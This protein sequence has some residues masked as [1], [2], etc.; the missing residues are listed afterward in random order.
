M[1]ASKNRRREQNK[2]GHNLAENRLRRDKQQNAA[3][4]TADK[5]NPRQNRH[6]DAA[7]RRRRRK[8]VARGIA[9][10]DLAWEQ[11]DGVRRVGIDGRQASGDERGKGE[12]G[13][14]ASNGVD[15]ARRECRDSYDDKNHDT[16]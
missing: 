3:K 12:K 1:A 8:T 4:E 9:R 6:I 5:T 15:K 7:V 10:R 13:A 2:P 11:R 16:A 14:A